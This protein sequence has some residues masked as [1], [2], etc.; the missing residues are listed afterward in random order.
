M[1]KSDKM[2]S[3]VRPEFRTNLPRQLVEKEKIFNYKV[4]PPSAE[5]SAK[6]ELVNNGTLPRLG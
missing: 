4:L 2:N 1:I 5:I 3:N 6:I